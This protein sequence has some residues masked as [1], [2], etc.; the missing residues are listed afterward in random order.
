MKAV[1]GFVLLLAAYGWLSGAVAGALFLV[2]THPAWAT[3]VHAIRFAAELVAIALAGVVAL[4]GGARLWIRWR[5]AFA[6]IAVIG[7]L[8]GIFEAFEMSAPF[9]PFLIAACTLGLL[10]GT[11]LL[12][13]IRNRRANALF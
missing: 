2:I 11:A 7:G 5:R 1:L 3:G 6:L 9:T 8:L 13:T 4:W 10:I 12:Y